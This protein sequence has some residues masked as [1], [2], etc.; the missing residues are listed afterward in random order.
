MRVCVEKVDVLGWTKSN[1]SGKFFEEYWQEAYHILECF[2]SKKVGFA[3][4]NADKLCS[5]YS[6]FKGRGETCDV[7]EVGDKGCIGYGTGGLFP[8]SR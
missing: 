1:D 4:I 2:T 6:F 8:V 7:K 3:I 5:R